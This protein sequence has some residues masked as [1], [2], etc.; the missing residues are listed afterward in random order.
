MK[1]STKKPYKNMK[2]LLELQSNKRKQI[3]KY[4]APLFGLLEKDLV[5]FIKNVWSVE[6]INPNTLQI[7]IVGKNTFTTNINIDKVE[8]IK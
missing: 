7:K 8:V 2:V 3:Y 5:Y 6:L 1:T 4:L